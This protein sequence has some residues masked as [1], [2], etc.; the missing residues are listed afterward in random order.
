MAELQLKVVKNSDNG[1]F[2]KGFADFV[3]IYGGEPVLY[4]TDYKKEIEIFE[5]KALVLHFVKSWS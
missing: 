1:V 4:T 5:I 2:G 3:S